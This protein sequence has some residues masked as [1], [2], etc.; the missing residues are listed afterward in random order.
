[1]QFP[2]RRKHMWP[3]LGCLTNN[4]DSQRKQRHSTSRPSL[5][6]ITS[7]RWLSSYWQTRRK[8]ILSWIRH[9][10][11][12]SKSSEAYHKMI[13][14]TGSLTSRN[15]NSWPKTRLNRLKQAKLIATLLQNQLAEFLEPWGRLVATNR[16]RKRIKTSSNL[17]RR[18]QWMSLSRCSIDRRPRK[19]WGSSSKAT[20]K[21]RHLHQGR[22]PLPSRSLRPI[23]EAKAQPLHLPERSHLQW[24][25]ASLQ[26]WEKPFL[27][28]HSKKSALQR[29]LKVPWT[30]SQVSEWPV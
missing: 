5:A 4:P 6:W 18:S 22:F 10:L 30:K 1:M 19:E 8:P 27:R 25:Q 14:T 9:A 26:I 3:L 2:R 17:L 13:L 15:T 29:G 28:L 12:K 11:Q 7:V 21:L 23:E 24:L 16:R 20:Q